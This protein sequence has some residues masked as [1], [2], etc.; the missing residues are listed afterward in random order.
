MGSA[1][2]EG[3]QMIHR[4]PLHGPITVD[5]SKTIM[6][7]NRTPLGSSQIIEGSRTF[8]R[9]PAGMIRAK[10]L[11]V[12]FPVGFLTGLYFP[13]MS[14]CVS[15]LAAFYL[16]TMSV[17]VHFL[18]GLYVC[19]MG[20]TV[21]CIAS[22]DLFTMGFPV[23]FLTGL[24]LGVMGSIGGFLSGLD[25]FAMGFPVDV[26]VGLPVCLSLFAMGSIGGLT[27]HVLAMATGGTF[28]IATCTARRKLVKRLA[29]TT[30]RTRF[31]RYWRVIG[32][33][34]IVNHGAYLLGIRALA[35]AS[36][37]FAARWER[38]NR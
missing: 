16:L 35:S 33:R 12:G 2:A 26:L 5:A 14:F 31:H 17:L 9:A 8:S 19:A 22:L 4:Q 28:P 38:V 18:S 3:R 30:S 32:R 24:Y 6:G 20:F 25:L 34:I 29:L 21:S 23:G 1:F 10:Y 37:V 15:F 7:F 27:E 13:T 36:G 11:R